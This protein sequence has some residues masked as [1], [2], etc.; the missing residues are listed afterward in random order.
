MDG[1][2]E[3]IRA[4]EARALALANADSLA[5]WELLHE[6]FQWTSHTGETFTRDDYIERN[7]AGSVAWRSQHFDDI[8]VVV[9]GDVAVLRGEVIDEITTRDG[10][11]LF[12]MPMTMVWVRQ[13][14]RW[15]CLAGHA[16]PRRT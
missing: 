5:L 16:G 2:P 12:R 4:A 10:F 11:E 3:V 8:D 6:D 9:V 1:R 13:G 7:T 14:D 15:C